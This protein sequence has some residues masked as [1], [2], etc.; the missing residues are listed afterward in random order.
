MSTEFTMIMTAQRE[1]NTGCS[2]T[3]PMQVE[4]TL[5]RTDLLVIFITLLCAGVWKLSCSLRISSA[6]LALLMRPTLLKLMRILPS[7]VLGL[8]GGGSAMVEIAPP[9]R[10]PGAE[11]TL[12]RP[13]AEIMLL[14]PA[15]MLPRSHSDSSELDLNILDDGSWAPGATSAAVAG[16][17]AGGSTK[18][19]VRDG[20][21]GSSALATAGDADTAA[22]ARAS[23]SCVTRS[24]NTCTSCRCASCR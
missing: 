14:R 13:G 11:I 6:D 20:W 12:L 5:T 10:W 22:S 7:N 21:G 24:R 4:L 18:N 15:R 23:A 1:S 9:P 17:P 8:A 2:T 3:R 16:L 19:D